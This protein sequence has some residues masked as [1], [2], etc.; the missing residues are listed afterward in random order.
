MEPK[1]DKKHLKNL[2]KNLKRL[3]KEKGLT[4]V[5]MGIDERTIRRIENEDFN[6][7]YLT[8]VHIAEALNITVS[9]LLSFS[10]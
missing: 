4:Q 5:D 1:E 2:S 6:P 7:S 3:R 10:K 8:L 9:E